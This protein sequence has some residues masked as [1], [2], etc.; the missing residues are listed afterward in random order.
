VSVKFQDYYEILGVAR[1]ASQDDIQKAYRKLARKYH[2]DVNKTKGAEE[3][4]K[5]IGEA[6]EVLKDPE[7]RKKYDMLGANWKAGQDFQPPP[8]WEGAFGN[9]AGAGGA[10]GAG[11][12]G[13]SRKASFNFGG[14]GDF[15]DF[16]SMMFGEGG[17]FAGQGQGA[18]GGFASQK[19][20]SSEAEL[21]ISIEDAFRGGERTITLESLDAGSDG[22]PQR[23]TKSYKIKIP[24]GMKDGG[25]IR[26]AGQGSPGLNGGEPGDLLLKI[27]I[28]PHHL[29]KLEGEELKTV[30]PLSPW[31]A[32][33]GA[34]INVRTLDGTIAVT[35]PAGAQSGQQLRLRGKGF[36]KSPKE[37]GDLLAELK[38]AVPKTLN[39]REKELFEQLSN[40]S[41]FNPRVV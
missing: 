20:R 23:K 13:R 16:F 41:S 3:K 33:L 2:P 25:A 12:R 26:L 40:E 31:E 39:A 34:K 8:G 7:K 18:P 29:F 35:V 37:R 14:M 1:D 32:A 24:A 38:V 4:F 19:G 21:A 6:N 36:P 28:L 27:R 5:K 30:L 17:S 11:A 10:A 22:S 15:S 9:F